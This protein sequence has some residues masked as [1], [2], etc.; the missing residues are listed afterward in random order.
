MTGST[1]RVDMLG[2]AASPRCTDECS[3]CLP[4]VNGAVRCPADGSTPA[5]DGFPA[6]S[7]KPSQLGNAPGGP[8]RLLAPC[9]PA[10]REAVP[11]VLPIPAFRYAIG[12]ARTAATRSDSP[13]AVSTASSHVVEAPRDPGGPAA[14]RPSWIDPTAACECASMSLDD[15]VTQPEV[16]A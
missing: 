5:S 12:H 16:A 3:A 2:V 15:G 11:W 1:A 10:G 13:M 4:L 14:G 8:A 6:F 9:V 7:G